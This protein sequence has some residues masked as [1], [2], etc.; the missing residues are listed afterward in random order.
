[1]KRILKENGNVFLIWNQFG[2]DPFDEEMRI[3]GEKYRDKT[4]IKQL[5][6]TREQRAIH[7]FGEG[8]YQKIE[9]DNSILQTWE[10]FCGGW[11]SASY[12]PKQ[13]TDSYCEFLEQA[14][15]LFEKYATNGL[16]KTTVKTICFFGHLQ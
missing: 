6:I 4:K 12:I 2:G 1:M 16:L 11:S 10:N 8:N 7:L 13:G 15:S 5:G 14:K 9:F 3:I